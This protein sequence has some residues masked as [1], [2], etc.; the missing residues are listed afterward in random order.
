MLLSQPQ[1]GGTFSLH[2][3]GH[4]DRGSVFAAGSWNGW[5]ARATP[6]RRVPSGWLAELEA[7]SDTIAY[8]FVVDGRWL[9]DPQNLH[10]A[11]DGQGGE[12]SVLDRARGGAYALRFY[13]PAL[14]EERSYTLSLPPGYGDG[15]RRFPVLYLLHGALDWERTWLDKGALEAMVAR[16]RSERALGDLIVVMPSENG[17]LYR[18][19]GRVAD[20]LARD[21]VGHIDFELRTLAA[22]EHRALDGLS[23]GGFTS[24][25]LGADRPDLFASI[26][27][28]SGSYDARASARI[29]QRARAIREA[30][31]RWLISCGLDEP[32]FAR[33]RAL[34]EELRRSDIDA[35]WADVAGGHDWPVWRALLG[36]HLAFH[37]GQLAP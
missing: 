32:H 22:R 14:A 6:M 36:A 33:C 5:D 9:R 19:D 24:L 35:S 34:Y 27:S 30:G 2:L 23:T 7:E 18:G 1:R 21:V 25:V 26:G 3:A 37:W 17:G 29:E 8:K 13:S 10:T 4:H 16:L 11:P 20:Y 31:Q 28:M 12:N 15:E